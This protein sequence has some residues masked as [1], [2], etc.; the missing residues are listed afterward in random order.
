MAFSKD[1]T[2][3]NHY[4]TIPDELTGDLTAGDFV[5]VLS[6]IRFRGGLHAI[7]LDKDARQFLVDCVVA[8]IGDRSR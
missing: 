6:E 3:P 4:P 7:R 2:S 5:A 1:A 8:R